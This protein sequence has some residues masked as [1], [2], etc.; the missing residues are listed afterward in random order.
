VSAREAQGILQ[1]DVVI[2]SAVREA[3]RRLR[4]NPRL[5]DAIFENLRNDPITAKEYGEKEIAQAKSWFYGDESKA[6]VDIPVV[7][8]YRLSPGDNQL[9]CISISLM[10]SSEAEVTLGDVHYNPVE[11]VVSDWPPIAGPFTPDEYVASSGILALPPSAIGDIV[12][13]PGMSITDRAGTPHLILQVL[14]D[15]V[16][17]IA[18]GTVA[19]FRNCYLKG[20]RPRLSETVESETMR[21]T[22][23]LGVHVAGEPFLLTYLHAIVQFSLL[24]FK[25]ELLEARGIERT[26]ISSSEFIRSNNV[27]GK[28]V[29][30]SRGVTINGYVRQ[31]WPKKVMQ[32]V[33]AF[34][35]QFVMEKADSPDPVPTEGDPDSLWVAQ[36]D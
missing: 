8:S 11:A 7:M 27:F 15:G 33:D 2:W 22:Y 28:E 35:P 32:V 30:F 24:H 9:P 10:E 25:E 20:C 6:P 4:G 36:S 31:I 34:T 14:D 12:L 1:T 19:D 5:F 3:L 21:E 18:P 13:L 29:V 17:S 16:V 26:S 23:Q